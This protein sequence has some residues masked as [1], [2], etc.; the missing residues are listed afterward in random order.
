MNDS[1]YLPVRQSE[2]NEHD[3][4]AH[5]HANLLPTSSTSSSTHYNVPTT[6][7]VT[8]DL[9]AIRILSTVLALIAFIIL[10]IDGNEEFIAVSTCPFAFSV[11][12]V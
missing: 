3:I 10:V 5:A 8:F 11:H 2:E 1:Q 12:L 9:F 6:Y 4:S 7:G